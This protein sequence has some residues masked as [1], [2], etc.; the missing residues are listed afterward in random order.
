[1]FYVCHLL[2]GIFNYFMTA[3]LSPLSDIIYLRQ[4]LA[5]C[6][7]GDQHVPC[8]PGMWHW[9]KRFPKKGSSCPKWDLNYM[10]L[11]IY[12]IWEKNQ[13]NAFFFLNK[14][15]LVINTTFKKVLFV[16]IT[17]RHFNWEQTIKS[18]S[19]FDKFNLMNIA[20]LAFRK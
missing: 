10:A 20:K 1:M 13:C 6:F 18:F 3:F 12:S 4:M 11:R 15:L 2:S 19:I 7:T 14:L 17:I 9:P 5:P 8:E 16:E